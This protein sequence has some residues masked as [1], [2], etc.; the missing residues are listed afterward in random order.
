MK[1]LPFLFLFLAIFYSSSFSQKNK[2]KKM[3]EK[4]TVTGIVQKSKGGVMIV[5][6]K[7]E[8]Y[9]VEDLSDLNFLDDQKVEVTGVLKTQTETEDLKDENGNYKQG[10]EKGTVRKII[11]KATW[12]IL[13]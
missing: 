12:K 8:I 11:T 1:I 6:D 2:R 7:K 13:S 10:Y 5:T 4:I 9:Y 3:K